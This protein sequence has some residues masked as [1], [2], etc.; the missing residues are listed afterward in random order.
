MPHETDNFRISLAALLRRFKKPISLTMAL[1]LAESTLGL[2]FPLFIGFAINGLLVQS[3]NG[4]AA[5]GGLGALALA[6]GTWRRYY[7]TRAYARIYEELGN[8]LVASEQQKDVQVSAVVART[9]M[10]TE[11]VEFLENSMPSIVSSSIGLVGTLAI[12]ASLNVAVFVACMALFLAM[13]VLYWLTGPRNM[14][15]NRG[16]ND[17]LERRVS[18]LESQNPSEINSHFR[19]LMTWNIKLSDLET[20]NY[21]LIWV[22][23]IGLF[24]FAPISVIQGGVTNY[25]MV[26]S[27]L[28]YVFQ[29]IESVTLLPLF[30]QQI[31]RLKEIAGRLSGESQ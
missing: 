7:D 30:I 20:A 1:V 16:Y 5:L 27:I 2:L 10:L 24:V 28:M 11:F 19:S 8:E 26:F 13:L 18:V 12:L 31:I 23:V 6:V 21:G 29:F 25:G 3:Y 15:L 4:V 17:E 9:S 22:G 14:A